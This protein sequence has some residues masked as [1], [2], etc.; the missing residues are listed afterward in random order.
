MDLQLD[1]RVALVTGSYRG[2][3]AGIARVLAA[4]GAQVLVHGFE[5]GQPDDVV[6]EIVASGGR[7][8]AVVADITTDAGARDL[9][10]VGPT[11][12][13]LVNNFG[14]PVG[15]NWDSLDQWQHAWNVN[16]LTSVRVAQ[17]CMP[18]MRE[19]SWGRIIFLGTIGTQRPG[20]VNPGYYGAKTALPTVV[21]TLAMELRGSGVTA[22]VVSPG[23]IA[24]DEMRAMVERRAARAGVDGGWEAAQKWALANSMPNLTERIPD[25]ED[26]GAVVAFLASDAAWHIN[27]ADLAV[28]G[29][30]RDAG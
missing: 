23:M 5:S 13:V 19:Q 21:R 24:T 4:E 18:A 30:A 20:K 29:G 7:A 16:V 1:G 22:N 27:G 11:V 10:H 26:I 12:D 25:P 17:L 8:E 14:K 15:S 28:D 2:T 3:G 9:A 6:A